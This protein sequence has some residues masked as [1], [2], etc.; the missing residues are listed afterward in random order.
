VVTGDVAVFDVAE[1][2][3]V[4]GVRR[5]GIGRA[6]A[7]ELFRS[8]PGRWEVRVAEFNVTAQRFWR[9]VIEQFAGGL[10]QTDAWTRDD[11]SR[12]TVFRF[13]SAGTSQIP[14]RDASK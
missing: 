12:W 3:V 11:G 9:S 13:A 8:F 14:P 6:A 10:L 5:R 4:R 2:F 7:C 1:F